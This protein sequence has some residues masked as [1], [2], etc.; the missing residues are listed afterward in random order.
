MKLQESPQVVV[1]V[2][3]LTNVTYTAGVRD[4]VFRDDFARFG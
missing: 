3:I 1:K 2:L 4:V